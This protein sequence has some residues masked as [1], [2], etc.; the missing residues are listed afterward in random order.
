MPKGALFVGWG[1]LI[2]GREEAA[3]KVLGEA[4]QYL[5][6]LRR[7]GTIDSFE[8]VALEP[9]G[10]DLAGFV[11]AKG[12]Q[13]KVARLRINDEFVRIAIRVQLV[14]NNV[15]VVGAWTGAEMESLFA[16]WDEEERELT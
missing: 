7:E 14:H 15:G 11:L 5:D 1:P 3:A 8:A 13:E 4:I 9:H 16:V 12:D 6:R 10:G 2:P